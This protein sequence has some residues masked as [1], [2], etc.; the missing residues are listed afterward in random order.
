ME[1]P[2][3]YYPRASEERV[4]ISPH[5]IATSTLSG[6]LL[7]DTNLET[8]NPDTY[9]PPPAPIPYNV[10]IGVPQTP[11]VTQEMCGNKIDVVLNPAN[12][13]P[14]QV[15]VSGHN[16]GATLKSEEEKVSKCKL[17]AGS[18][19]DTANESEIEL[20]KS[21]EHVFEEEDACPI[22][23]DEYDKDN[24][25]LTPK[26][27]HHFHLACILEW[28]ER[29]DTCPVCEKNMIFDPPID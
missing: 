13:T 23:L 15:A 7:V 22:C 20:S 19:L 10:A 14:V 9:R 6:G 5:D 24:P 12:C 25:K 27:E 26:C 16:D 1:P 18:K 2:D 28:M 3:Y 11:P 21:V 29:S 8:S 4:P 17:D